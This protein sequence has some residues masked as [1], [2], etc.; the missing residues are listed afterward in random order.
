VGK[1]LKRVSISWQW[2]GEDE[3]MEAIKG[4]GVEEGKDESEDGTWEEGG[5]QF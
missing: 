3:G 5:N 2:K 1:R 4:T